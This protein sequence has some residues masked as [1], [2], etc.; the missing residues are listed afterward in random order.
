MLI[1]SNANPKWLNLLE[2]LDLVCNY[3]TINDFPI[4]D[5]FKTE[6]QYVRRVAQQTTINNYLSI[7][8]KI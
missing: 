1:F 6:C 4:Q 8:R 2:F 5:A 3:F 7:G